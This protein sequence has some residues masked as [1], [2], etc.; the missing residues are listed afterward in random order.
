ML[1]AFDQKGWSGQAV[2]SKGGRKDS[3]RWT[4]TRKSRNSLVEVVF[5][6]CGCCGVGIEMERR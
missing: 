4:R 3:R 5:G 1:N 6:S 2:K